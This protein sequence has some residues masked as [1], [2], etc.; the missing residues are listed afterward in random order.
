MALSGTR[1]LRLTAY[2]AAG[3]EVVFPLRMV[4][5]DDGRLGCSAT[6][7]L[8]RLVHRDPRVRLEEDRAATAEVLRSGRA[9]AEV[10]G[11]LR[12]GPPA[13][14]YAARAGAGDPARVTCQSVRVQI[15]ETDGSCSGPGTTTTPPGSWT[16]RAGSR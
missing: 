12:R 2:N 4:T 14:P 3:A 7:D 1:Q 6:P 8:I 13:E 5:L 11:R 15:L 9:F 10:H 16:S